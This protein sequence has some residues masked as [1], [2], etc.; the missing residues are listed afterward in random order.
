MNREQLI[1]FMREN[2]LNQPQIAK[3]IGVNKATVCR[4]VHVDSLHP[5]PESKSKLLDFIRDTYKK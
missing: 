3:L 1:K 2:E 5:I 4:W